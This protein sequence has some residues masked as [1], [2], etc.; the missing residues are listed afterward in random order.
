MSG[1]CVLC[2]V[3]CIIFRGSCPRLW[4]LVFLFI[5]SIVYAFKSF[6]FVRSLWR[7]LRFIRICCDLRTSLSPS[8]PP[9]SK[10]AQ[11][12]YC[13][14][15]FY[16]LSAVYCLL[17]LGCGLLFFALAHVIAFERPTTLETGNGFYLFVFYFLLFV[18]NDFAFLS[19][20]RVPP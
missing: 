8:N 19:Y 14:S 15:F 18:T 3:Y 11:H 16:L 2:I 9:S 7:V 12:W 5:H 20:T 6:R 4:L 1:V 10:Q 13:L 17:S